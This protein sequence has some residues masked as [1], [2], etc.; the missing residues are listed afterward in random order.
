MKCTL[1]EYSV[2]LSIRLTRL[3]LRGT[4]REGAN[5]HLFGG[6]GCRGAQRS[7]KPRA[8]TVETIVSVKLL[9]YRELCKIPDNY[10]YTPLDIL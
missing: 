1:Y 10:K 5:G 7:S 6:G 3:K 8:L 4:P 2:V 9:V